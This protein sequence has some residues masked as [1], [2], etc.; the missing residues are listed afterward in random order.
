MLQALVR[1]IVTRSIPIPQPAVGGRPYSSEV[2]NPSST[3]C[4]SSSPASL[5]WKLIGYSVHMIVGGATLPELVVGTVPSVPLDHSTQ[6]RHY[7]FLSGIRIIQ[8]SR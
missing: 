4:A 2:Q 6:Y 3:I 5:S 1:N 8:I 7:K